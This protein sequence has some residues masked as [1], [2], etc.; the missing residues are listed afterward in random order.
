MPSVP[1]L[2]RATAFCLAAGS[3]AAQTAPLNTTPDGLAM[4]GF[5]VV[6]YFTEGAPAQGD[7]AN[8]V[9][10]Q[11]A[12]WLFASPDNAALFSADP[13]RYAP[14]NN[15]WCSYAVSEGYS[16]EVDFV[17][18]WSVLDGAL[19]LNWD[20]SVRDTFLADREWRIPA[21]NENWPTVAA[22]LADGSITTYRHADDSSVGITHPQSLK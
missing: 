19:Y 4:D 22:G 17:D 9:E 14:R 16:A 3:A 10:Y 12:R 6:A 7:P 21:A 20:A 18:G 13:A 5:D 11:G 15:G 1:T 2:V 8:A